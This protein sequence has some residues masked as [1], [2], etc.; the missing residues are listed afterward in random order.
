MSVA[1]SQTPILPSYDPPSPTKE[2]LE[3]ADLAIIDLS[4]TATPEGRVQFA[5]EIRQALASAGFF[6]VINHGYT[7]AQ[8][9]HIFD[10]A[11]AAF[12]QVSLQEKKE[13]DQKD[14]TTYRGY[15]LK[16]AWHIDG[17]IRDEIETYNIHRSVTIQPHP[18]ALRQFLPDISE[19]A[20]HNH[21]NV[22]FPILRALALT[23]ELPEDSL[24]K[25]HG[26][27]ELGD[28]R[29][30]TSIIEVKRYTKP[31]SNSALQ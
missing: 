4:K 28:S 20:K 31:S 19:F 27:N 16:N 9:K 6:Y 18:P 26:F 23:L 11:N 7:D 1:Q 3:F 30:E 25:L 21:F 2:N 29:G 5:H 10:I 22:L 17:E 14:I 8:T 12:S 13:F 15:K 24:T